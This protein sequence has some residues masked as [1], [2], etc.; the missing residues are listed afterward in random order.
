M[1][2]ILFIT[3]IILS[4][5]FAHTEK[6]IVEITFNELTEFNQFRRAN[7]N[8]NYSAQGI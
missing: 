3:F 2:S 8:V 5:I 1:K 7:I 6:Q 4:V